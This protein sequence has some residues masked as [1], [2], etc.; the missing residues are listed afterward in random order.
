MFDHYKDLRIFQLGKH[1]VR[2]VIVESSDCEDVA[3]YPFYTDIKAIAN[4]IDPEI[5]KLGD[6][7]YLQVE[8]SNVK[9]IC[10][11]NS[12]KLLSVKEAINMLAF[13]E[14]S[15]DDSRMYRELLKRA[16]LDLLADYQFN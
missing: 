13:S 14:L 1:K 4:G 2:A 10:F 9:S 6:A 7:N 12:T 3:V 11:I 5:A 8:G 15:A 16:E